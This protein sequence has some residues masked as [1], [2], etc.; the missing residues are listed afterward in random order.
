L[1]DV[2]PGDLAREMDA[3]IDVFA[4]DGKPAAGHDAGGREL[5]VE[6]GPRVQQ[7]DTKFSNLRR[8]GAKD[9]LGVASFERKQDARLP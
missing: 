2:E 1:A 8:D 7:A 5:I 9:G 6:E 3:V 4:L